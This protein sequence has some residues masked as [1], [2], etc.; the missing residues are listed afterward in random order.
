MA[1]AKKPGNEQAPEHHEAMKRKGMRLIQ[2]WVPDTRTPEFAELARRET[3]LIDACDA[4]D[5]IMEFL[6]RVSIFDDPDETW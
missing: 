5:D 6:E 3:A 1:L 2:R 4:E